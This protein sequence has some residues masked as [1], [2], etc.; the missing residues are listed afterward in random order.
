MKYSTFLVVALPLFLSSCIV[1]GWNCIEGEGEVVEKTLELND[2]DELDL[3][4]TATLRYTQEKSTK[5]SK[6]VV[7]CEENLIDLIQFNVDGRE[8]EITS[9]KCLDGQEEIRI[10]LV[11][12]GL[13]RVELDGSGTVM[14]TNT[15]K[16]ENLELEIDGSGDL[17]FDVDAEDLSTEIDGSGDAQLRGKVDE[18]DI[19]INGS[20]DLKA[21]EL[22]TSETDLKINGS[23]DCSIWAEERLN[24]RIN[25][26]GDV[27]YKGQPSDM[28]Q[29]VNGSGEV[30]TL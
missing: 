4:I 1:G 21:E 17:M 14:T 2:I 5:T 26:S 22:K 25:G 27:N 30:R 3:S 18:H 19:R 11:T 15:L 12:S 23:G 20:G 24:I 28:T 7:R 6:I 9:E 29:K 10:E 13:S 8:L 16:T